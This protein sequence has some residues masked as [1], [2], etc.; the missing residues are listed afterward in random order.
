[1]VRLWKLYFSI[2][3][4]ISKLLHQSASESCPQFRRCLNVTA[5]CVKI[6]NIVNIPTFPKI[7]RFLTISGA[8]LP[9]I[10][11]NIVSNHTALKLEGLKLRYDNISTITSDALSKLSYIKELDLSGNRGISASNVIN[12]VLGL[13]SNKLSRS[14]LNDLLWNEEPHAL[15]CTLS[16]FQIKTLSLNCKNIHTLNFTIY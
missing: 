13:G 11:R 6:H 4:I 3:N 5:F 1:M 14:K 15:Y 9:I 10:N 8:N 12:A 16:K 2:T 7:T